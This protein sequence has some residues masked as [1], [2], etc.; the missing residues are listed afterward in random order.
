MRYY[1]QTYK[2]DIH[3]FAVRVK[4]YI[5]DHEP[6]FRLNFFVDEV[7]QFIAKDSNLM[8]NLQSVAEELATVC[9]G[10]SWVVVTSQENMEDTI[11]QMTDKSANDFSKIQARFK[12]KMQLT[13]KDAKEVIKQRLLAKSRD[14]VSALDVMYDKYRDD[15]PVLFDFADG[16]KRYVGY[17]DEDVL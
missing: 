15:F 5:D 13:S 14:A 3:S 16:S 6:G 12:I 11:G 1:Q 4:E 17:K 9:D 8:T 2:P 10:A 7:G